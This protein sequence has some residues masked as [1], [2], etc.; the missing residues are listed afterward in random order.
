LGVTV[1]HVW[2]QHMLNTSMDDHNL[3]AILANF[4]PCHTADHNPPKSVANS[5]DS[6]RLTE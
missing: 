2:C 4:G 3:T 6:P 5:W 1:M